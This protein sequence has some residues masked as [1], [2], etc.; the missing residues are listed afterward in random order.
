[1]KLVIIG[2]LFTGLMFLGWW[3]RDEFRRVFFQPRTSMIPAGIDGELIGSSNLIQGEDQL[4]ESVE[5]LAESLNIPWEVVELPDETLLV[6]ERPG[7]LVRIYP[8]TQER[9][10]ISGVAHVGEGGLLG[11]ALHPDFITTRWLYLYLTSQ[12]DQGLVNRVERYEFDE[13]GNV[14][15]ER[16]VIIDQVPGAQ[17]HDGGRIAFGPDQLLYITTGDAG[18]PDAAQDITSMAGKILRLTDDGSIPQDNPFDNA[19]YSYGH[20]NPQGLAWDTQGRLWATE[21]G[22]SGLASGFDEVNL[23]VAGGNYGWPLIQGEEIK[24]GMI[25]PVIQSGAED[26]W[27]P[28]GL[29]II[30]DQLFFAGLRGEALYSAQIE[31]ERLVQLQAHFKER[32]GRLRALTTANNSTSLLVTTSNR[33]GRGDINAGDDRLIR[34]DLQLF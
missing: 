13:A 10:A 27:A 8:N 20:R 24:R 3:Q 30:E 34:L 28:A 11:M 23:I 12:S 33:D 16:M 14:L 15:G 17:Y 19:V 1:M 5:V 22:P 26:T 9:R 25:A 32:Y 29:T 7:E 4:T 21:H 2:I 18:V 6:T 31:G